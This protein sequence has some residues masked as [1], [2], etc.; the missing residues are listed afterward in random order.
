MVIDTTI[1]K[2]YRQT[3]IGVIPEDWKVEQLKDLVSKVIDNRGKTPP[4]SNNPDIELIET[5]SISF[6]TQYPDYSKVTKFVSNETYENWFRGHPIKDDIL[7][8]TVGEYSGSSAI[9]KGNRGTIAQNLIALRIKDAQPTYVF[10]WTRSKNFKEQLDQVM[11]NQAQPSLRV[12]WLLNFYLNIPRPEEQTAMA[13]VL[14]DTDA[15]IERFEKLIVKKKGVKQGAMQQL[16][17]GKIRLPGFG[18]EW[19]VKNLGDLV[20]HISS[21]IY[22]SETQID[23]LIPFP[24]ATTAHI[25]E[26]NTW[27]E[28][29]MSIRYFSRNQVAKYT[30]TTGD[31]VVVKSS[32]SAEKIKSGKLGFVTDKTSGKFIFSNFLMLLRPTIADSSFL[33]YFL[34]SYKVKSILPNLCEASTYPNLR[35]NEYLDIDV[36]YP[37]PKEQIAIATVLSDMDS[38]IESLKQKRDKYTMLKQGMMQ[39]LLT[40]GIRTYANN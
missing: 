19:E 11:M 10:Y 2:G 1:K 28:K 34:T 24:V 5:A 33:Y 14:S 36:P 17:T 23:D 30:V 15:L 16:L 4:Y 6:V 8:S 13:S 40:G 22:G 35:I 20:T 31:I 12:P 26:D 21:G 38:E 9:M 7:V 3:E 29:P 18:G 37:K 27:N 32:G 25:N 39:Q